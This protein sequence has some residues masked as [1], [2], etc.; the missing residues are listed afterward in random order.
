MP[1][2]GP[3]II[4]VRLDIR[5]QTCLISLVQIKYLISLIE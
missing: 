5:Q 2:D 1:F 4:L 3:S